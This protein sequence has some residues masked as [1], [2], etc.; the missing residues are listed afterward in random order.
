MI[1]GYVGSGKST[2]LKTIAGEREPW[3]LNDA[4]EQNIE[5]D[6]FGD[7]AR[8]WK[9]I[10][11]CALDSDLDRLPDGT[12]TLAGSEGCNLS[13]GQKQ[14]VFLARGLTIGADSLL[15]DDVFSVLD[16]PTASIIRQSLFG[17]G[18]YFQEEPTT[19]FTVTNIAQHLKDADFVF[20]VNPDGEAV[21]Q[22]RIMSNPTASEPNRCKGNV[23]DDGMD[24]KK[25][26]VVQVTLSD[27]EIKHQCHGDWAALRILFQ[28]CWA[29]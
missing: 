1:R 11:I 24:S 16:I 25:T 21:A 28:G 12:M 22:K 15:L 18:G 7:P 26:S 4:L 2:I 19:L 17:K 20:E 13:G 10:E 9:I 3:G 27:T 8:L 23:S 29:A 14:A 6:S 5:G